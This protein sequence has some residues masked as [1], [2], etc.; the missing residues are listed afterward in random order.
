MITASRADC[1][2]NYYVHKLRFAQAHD[3]WLKPTLYALCMTMC[4]AAAKAA[5]RG[6]EQALREV[7]RG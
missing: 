6:E 5:L 4:T 3:L 2:A 7:D 1:M